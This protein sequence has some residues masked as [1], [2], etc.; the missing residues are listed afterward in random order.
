MCCLRCFHVESIM[1]LLCT[2][3]PYYWSTW[4]R[5]VGTAQADAVVG[6][7]ALLE[8]CYLL[9]VTKKRLHGSVC[10]ELCPTPPGVGLHASQRLCSPSYDIARCRSALKALICGY[11]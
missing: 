5:L 3:G 9:L 2:C 11:F 8:G 10:G 6:C 7:F 4:E 1:F